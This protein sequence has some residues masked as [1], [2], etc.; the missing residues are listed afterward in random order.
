MI[1]RLARY[2]CD[3]TTRVG[4][5]DDTTARDLDLSL[6][7]ALVLAA[8]RCGGALERAASGTVRHLGSVTLLPPVATD[9]R[10]FCVGINYL[11][12]QRESADVFAAEVPEH[13]IVFLKDRSALAA[14]G[15]E[16]PLP[17]SVSTA[18]DWEVE[19][20]VV[21]GAPARAISPAEAWPVVAGFT[22]VNDITARDLQRR[23]SQWCLGKNVEAATPVGPW[24]R[25]VGDHE[26]NA[27]VFE[28]ELRVNGV[29]KQQDTTSEMI[30]GLAELI[31]SISQVTPL[32]PGDVIATGTP[33]GVGF[34]R[35]PPEHLCDGDV[36]EATIHGVG[37]LRNRVVT[38]P[39]R[40][41]VA[42]ITAVSA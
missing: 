1:P 24:I 10:I 8:A 33:S 12:H 11:E 23:H 17:R 14:P 15:A 40:A 42:P 5:V 3:G 19:L 22:V 20:G 38:E 16:L 21:I 34:K 35:T 13:P 26:A 39:H 25:L 9:G 27:P 2:A 18:F 41:V 31:S 7:D 28:L 36:V 32:L 4:L 6:R 37:T 30:F 29:L